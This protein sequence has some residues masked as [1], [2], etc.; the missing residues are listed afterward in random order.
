MKKINQ[1]IT[2]NL[3]IEEA[4]EYNILVDRDTLK[5]GLATDDD[6]VNRCP[7]CGKNFTKENYF[8]ALCGQ[9]VR[10]IVSDVIPL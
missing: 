9:R 6:N 10:F 7:I 3:T 4:L 5:D 8:C 1:K 2:V